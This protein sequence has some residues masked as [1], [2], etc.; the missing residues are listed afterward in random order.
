M[1]YKQKGFPMHSTKSAFKQKVRDI[2]KDQ[3]IK[4]LLAAMNAA[5]QKL[6][7]LGFRG[8][9]DAE[10]PKFTSAIAAFQKASAAYEAAT[11]E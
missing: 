10:D 2:R 4:R 11:K 5:S 6:T 3:E 8:G 7:D 1:A 9:E